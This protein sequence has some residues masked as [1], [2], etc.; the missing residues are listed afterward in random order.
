MNFKSFLINN[1]KTILNENHELTLQK[2]I[3]SIDD[4]HVDYSDNK[5]TFDVGEVAEIPKL[6]GL[7]IIIR[8]SNKDSVRLGKDTNGRYSIVVDSSSKLPD[9]TDIDKFLSSV[10][11][12]KGVSQAYK[13]YINLYFDNKKESK[14]TDTEENV[15]L[16]NRTSFEDAY[17]SI[18]KN[19]RD[20][21]DEY[22]ATIAEID[23]ELHKNANVG[24][25]HSLELAKNKI[26]NEYI[27]KDSNEFLSKVKKLPAATILNK[28]D[29]E[30]LAKF[31]S[32]IK[33]FYNTNYSEE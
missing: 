3:D 32:R 1:N 13:K 16:N 22:T 31:D 33:S 11:I 8:K 27:G 26:K 2:I 6:K 28:L 20:K 29:K 25:K 10:K 18:I 14:L 24:K 12:Y 9:R 4:K 30:W 17:N 15:L 19:I 21:H 23:K 5:I 7:N